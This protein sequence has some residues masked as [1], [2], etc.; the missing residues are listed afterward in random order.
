MKVQLL[1]LGS[2]LA[3]AV[4]ASFGAACGGSNVSVRA[5]EDDD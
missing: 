2:V 4:C 1:F 3:Q 5:S